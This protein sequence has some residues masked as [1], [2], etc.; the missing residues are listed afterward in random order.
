MPIVVT[1]ASGFIGRHAV[2]AFRRASPQ[3]RAYVRRPE[4]AGPLRGLGAVVAVGW[5]DDVDNLT[6][7]MS[8]AHTVCHLV[9][10]ANLPAEALDEV[11]VGSTVAVL[12][13]AET[14]GVRRFMFVSCAGA[15]VDSE[16]PFLKSKGL[17]EAA[18][19]G[20]NMETFILRCAPVYGPEPPTGSD[21]LHRGSGGFPRELLESIG[22]R[23]LAPVYVG[24]VAEILA[25]ADDRASRISGTWSLEGPD[26]VPA[27][28]LAGM[29]PHRRRR[30][31]R[32]GRS[33]V[34]VGWLRRGV[35]EFALEALALGGV[36]DAPDAAAEFG[37]RRTT[38]RDGLARPL[39]AADGE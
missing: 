33:P 23:R 10:N 11:N 8:G 32:P 5:I 1:G 9:G 28:D 25:A 17:A 21:P 20:S 3:V 38:L 14:A 4:T 12:K 36:S 34:R 7:V 30:I 18:L 27:R 2:P 13:A 37:I 22:D 39:A 6:A 35:S 31:G 26:R 16:N 29:V 15:S 19:A 24:D